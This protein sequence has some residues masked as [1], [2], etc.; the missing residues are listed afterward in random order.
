MLRSGAVS[1]LLAVVVATFGPTG[2][3]ANPFVPAGDSALRHDIQLLSDFGVIKGPTTTW[4]LA[5]GP[6]LAEVNGFLISVDTPPDVAS[7]LSRVKSRAAWDTRLGEVY[8]ESRVSAADNPKR[9]R[10]YEDT[11]RTRAEAGAAISYTG[12]WWAAT[13]NAQLVDVDENDNDDAVRFD[14]SVVAASFGNWSIGVNTLDRWWGPGWDGSVILS[15][16]AR[17]IPSVSIDRIFTDEFNSKWLSWIGPWDLSVHFGQMEEERSVPNTKF[18]GMRFNFKPIPT[19]EIGLSRT[20]QWCGDGRPCDLDTFLDLLIGYD[21]VGDDDITR[22]NEPGN[23]LAG[24]DARWSIRVLGVPLAVYG[25]FIGEDEAG[26]LPSRYL[27]QFGIEGTGAVGTRWSYRW[28]AEY[29]GTSC[30]FYESSE[31]FNCAY[32]HGIYK[33]GYRYRGRSVGHPTDN[34]TKIVTVGLL[35]L[36]DTDSEWAA[37]IRYGALNRG[38]APDPA[39][40]LTPT[41]QDIVS[42]DLRHSKGFSFGEVSAGLGYERIDDEV[43]GESNDEVR[44]FL[45]W[46]SSY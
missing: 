29:A 5:W 41:R 36:S 8:F 30:Q 2:A 22:E 17:P 4:P 23:Q 44:F 21:N 20:A 1:T 11:P 9:I 28:F 37:T 14:R 26:G 43:S 42:I 27:G 13:V 18:F 40:T 24:F 31:L 12:N 39:N 16:N 10:S 38:G 32:N 46:R 3:A 25:Q 15:N 35:A 6:L 33:T 7:A 19:L 34:D 45:Q